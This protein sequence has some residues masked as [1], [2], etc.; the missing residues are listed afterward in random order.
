VLWMGLY[1]LPFME[2]LHVSV[3]N[4]LAHVAQSKL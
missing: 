4:L 2:V 1:P 3:D